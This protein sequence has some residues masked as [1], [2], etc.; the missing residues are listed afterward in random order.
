VP[1]LVCCADF[2]PA[3]DSLALGGSVLVLK[4]IG[5]E[6][7][8]G[9]PHKKASPLGEIRKLPENRWLAFSI[10]KVSEHHV[11]SRIINGH[12]DGL[13]LQQKPRIAVRR[14]RPQVKRDAPET[15]RSAGQIR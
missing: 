7:L 12:C 4:H 5:R 1:P 9:V 13:R 3:P 8:T 6:K 14:P 11:G 10:T 2:E 15:G